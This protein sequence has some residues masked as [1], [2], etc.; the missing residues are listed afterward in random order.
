MDYTDKLYACYVALFRLKYME[1]DSLINDLIPT[2]PCDPEKN[3]NCKKTE[4][5]MNGGECYRTIHKSYQMLTKE[6]AERM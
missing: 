4:C 2:Y 6:A 1:D 3:I 5:F